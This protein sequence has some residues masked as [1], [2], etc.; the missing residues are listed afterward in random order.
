MSSNNCYVLIHLSFPNKYTINCVAY[1]QQTFISYNSRGW[2][3]QDHGA[4]S[5]VINFS[6]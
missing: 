4:D 5:L 1:K 3:V 6:L 2:E